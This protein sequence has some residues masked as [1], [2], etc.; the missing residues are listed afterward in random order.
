MPLNGVTSKKRANYIPYPFNK[1][2][3]VQ[4]VVHVFVLFTGVILFLFL[5][6]FSVKN[7]HDFSVFFFSIGLFYFSS[8]QNC[9]RLL[10]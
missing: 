1:C 6:S 10:L 4:C 7:D 2:D 8:R 9:T 3:E 5:F